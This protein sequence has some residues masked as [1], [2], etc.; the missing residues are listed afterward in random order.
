MKS[1]NQFLKESIVDPLHDTLSPEVFDNPSSSD[2][3]IKPK[4]INLIK[5]DL[6]TIGKQVDIKDVVLVGSILTKRY[7][8]DTDLDV[9]ILAD[10][11]TEVMDRLSKDFSEKLVPGT[12]HPINY[13]IISSKKDHDRA[14]SLGD[15]TFDPI[16]NKFLR[17]PIDRA[18]DVSEYFAEFKKYVA[19]I[20]K[21]T[22]NLKHDLIDYAQLKKA[23][24]PQTEKLQ[25]MIEDALASIEK[26]SV[27]L[28]D[29]FAAIK[30]AR[31]DA[32][33]TEVTPD[34][35][36]KYGEKNRTP[37]NVIFKLLE[38]YHYLQFLAKIKEIIGDN[39]KVSPEE[40]DKLAALVSK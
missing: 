40:A 5:K 30:K 36:R 35:I 26:E 31:K 24:G 38:K 4:I 34:E 27:E 28:V 14:N 7:R 6:E 19:K 21:A 23:G 25:K 11:K 39:K 29:I 13:Y 37:G 18:F 9:H 20:T 17:K 12:D 15:G 16:N 8:S 10:G 1:F 22:S 33:A 32:F 3:T 2:A